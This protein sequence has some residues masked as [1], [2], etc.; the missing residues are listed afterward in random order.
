MNGR[1]KYEGG[2]NEEDQATP[3]PNPQLLITAPC[4]KLLK[5]T[6]THVRNLGLEERSLPLSPDSRP[7]AGRARAP[8]GSSRS[9]RPWSKLPGVFHVKKIG[10]GFHDQRR[11]IRCVY[12]RNDNMFLCVS[13]DTIVTRR[14]N[15]KKNGKLHDLNH[16]VFLVYM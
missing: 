14:G 9:R 1:E 3:N 11:C 15:A 2:V 12:V 16:H 13:Y 8:R 4:S 6:P 5:Y 10:G 7:D